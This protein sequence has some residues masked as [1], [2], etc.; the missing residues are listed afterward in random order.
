MQDIL[1]KCQIYDI[2]NL[3]FRIRGGF[4]C[5]KKVII[6]EDEALV[7]LGFKALL[8]Q[9]GYDV[10]GEAYDGHSAVSLCNELSPDFLIMDIKMPGLDGIQALEQINQNRKE[11]IP[12]IF[13]TAH[14]DE[15][16][17]ERAKHAGAFSYLIKPIRLESL[18]AAIN[19]ALERFEDYRKLKD[20]R[21]NAKEMLEQRKLIERAKGYLMDN[22]DMKEKQAMEFMQKKSCTTNK[23]L[24]EVARAIL[25]MAEQL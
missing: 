8:T 3:I 21:D 4:M 25:Q 19:V 10:V 14:S 1:I 5:Q 12:C 7:L 20:E 18:R 16:L 22:F 17:I 11:M 23:K 13:V 9:L 15:Y 24:V 2:L 6:A